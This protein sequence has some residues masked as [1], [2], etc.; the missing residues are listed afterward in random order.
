M[1]DEYGSD[2]ITLEDENGEEV[3]LELLTMTEVDGCSY[4]LC[5]PA[6]MDETD[7]NYGY[8]ILQVQ[9]ED[10]DPLA[11]EDLDVENVCFGSVDD[12]QL[13]Q[14]VYDTF[15]EELFADEDE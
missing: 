4:I 14:R 3:E 5:L 8:V 10:G 1:S 6:D 11:A 13:L 9:T 7:E 12:E 2:Y 15:M